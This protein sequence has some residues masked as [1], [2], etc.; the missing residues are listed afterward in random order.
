MYEERITLPHKAGT[1][2][3]IPLGPVNLVFII[4]DVGLVGCGAFDVKAL[5]RFKYPAARVR[6]IRTTN[7]TTLEDLQNG[8]IKDANEH[9]SSRGIHE[10]MPVR[11]ALEQL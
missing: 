2:Y 3:V 8:E 9:A 6:P 7:I 1:G 5:D 10:G 4:T 11:E